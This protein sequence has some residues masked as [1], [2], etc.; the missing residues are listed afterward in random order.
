MQVLA[1]NIVDA[2]RVPAF[3]AQGL[4]NVLWSFATLRYYPHKVLVAICEELHRRIHTINAQVGLT[5]Q[6]PLHG[7]IASLLVAMLCPHCSAHGVSL[8]CEQRCPAASMS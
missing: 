4:T 5:T 8:L 3:T 1:N 6:P 2:G 7:C